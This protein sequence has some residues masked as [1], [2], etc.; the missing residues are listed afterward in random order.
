MIYFVTEAFI[1]K[2][3]IISANADVNDY[4][5]LIQNAAKAFIKRQIGSLFFEDLLTKYN[6]QTL[7]NDE[8]LLVER[9]QWSIA[10][11]ACANAVIS[12]SFQLKNKG[13]QIQKSDNSDGVGLKEVSFM[14]DHY[15]QN[16]T[17]FEYELKEYLIAN[18]DKYSVYLSK[19]NSDSSIKNSCNGGDDNYAESSGIFII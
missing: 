9:M 19:E 5:P 15:I 17:Y 13:L 1:K 7:S 18:K 14:Y 16:A 11:R 10:W 6:N 8:Q 3:G 4:T 2:N 12:L